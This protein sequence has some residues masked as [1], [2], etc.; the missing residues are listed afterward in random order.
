MAYDNLKAKIR[1][2]AHQLAY[3]EE[4]GHHFQGWGKRR[5]EHYKLLNK[6]NRLEKKA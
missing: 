2:L 1:E 6:L 3:E 4:I 5:Q